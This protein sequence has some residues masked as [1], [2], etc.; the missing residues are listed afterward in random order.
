MNKLEPNK[1]FFDLE[2]AKARFQSIDHKK[3]FQVLFF[4]SRER[5]DY[6]QFS[7]YNFYLI[8]S[9]EDQIRTSFHD[10]IHDTLEELVQDNNVNIVSSDP[11][12]FSSRMELIEPSVTHIMEFGN[13]IFGEKEFS[14]QKR[15]WEECKKLKFDPVPLL[16]FLESRVKFYK[17]IR[18]KST[19]EDIARLEKVISLTIQ[20]WVISSIDDL[21]ITEIAFL[22]I[23]TR[24]PKLIKTLYN[25]KISKDVLLLTSVYEEI[26]DLKRSMNVLLTGSEDYVDKLKDSINQLQDLS[27][28]IERIV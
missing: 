4:G 15:K 1:F 20:T 19:K 6:T 22:D 21:S 27:R 24:M 25:S 5:G 26:H 17:S 10:M 14:N 3:P 7:D 13:I 28:E 18:P 23:P 9:A 16:S 11:D 8:A 2:S 12:S